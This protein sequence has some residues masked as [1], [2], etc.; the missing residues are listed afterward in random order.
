M[1]ALKKTVVHGAVVLWLF[2]G[3]ILA[4]V[5]DELQVRRGCGPLGFLA[6]ASI[7]I[8]WP[9]VLPA[10]IITVA[11]VGHTQRPCS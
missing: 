5:S 1:G 8:V 4:M 2:G 7:I 10:A 3:L 9:I 6:S 11:L